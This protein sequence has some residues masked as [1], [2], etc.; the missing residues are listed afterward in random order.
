VWEGSPP[1]HVNGQVLLDG[2]DLYWA[3]SV[4]NGPGARQWRWP[5]RVA[6]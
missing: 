4:A 6:E 5:E 3:T 2:N 1:I